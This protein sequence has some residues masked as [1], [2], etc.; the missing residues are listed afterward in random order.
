MKFYVWKK[1]KKKHER[2]LPLLS[3]SSNEDPITFNTRFDVRLWDLT[4]PSSDLFTSGKQNIPGK[5]IYIQS[6]NKALRLSKY[7]ALKTVREDNALNGLV[8]IE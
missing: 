7:R 2:F 5:N 4:Y 1:A 6:K 8:E 3:L